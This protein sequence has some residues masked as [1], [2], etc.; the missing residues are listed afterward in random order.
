MMGLFFVFVLGG[1]LGRTAVR[2]DN[3]RR[4][5]NSVLKASLRVPK[6]H[7]LRRQGAAGMLLEGYGHSNSGRERQGE[8]YNS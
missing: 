5:K 7:W 2:P 8:V 3:S 1:K 6:Q 4:P